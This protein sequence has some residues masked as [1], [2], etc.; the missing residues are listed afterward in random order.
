MEHKTEAAKAGLRALDVILKVGTDPIN[1][2]ADWERALR[3]NVGKQVQ[4]TI[5]RDKK[6]QTVSLQVDSKRHSELELFEIFGGADPE[7]VA[8]NDFVIPEALEAQADAAAA[9]AQIQSQIDAQVQ[10]LSDQQAEQMAKQAEQFSQQFNPDQF[11]VD[12]KQM[13]ELQQQMDQFKVDP[14]QMQEL[15]QQME[16]FKKGFNADQFKQQFQMDQKQMDQFKKNFN[17]DQFKVDPKQMQE[18]EQQM[19]QW[20]QQMQDQLEYLRE[21]QS[22][23]FV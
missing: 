7:L 3:S 8:E 20:K 4:V 18:F 12:P 9:Q 17:A 23:H 5:L 14:K 21:Q 13:Q 16:Q 15:Q 22:G 10:G 2:A 19:E 11:K 6:Q 1:T